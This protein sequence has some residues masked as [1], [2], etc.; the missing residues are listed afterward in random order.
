MVAALGYR[1]GTLGFMGM[2]EL[3]AQ[4]P[5]MASGNYGLL[6]QIHGL[7]W[8]RHHR[9]KFGAAAYAR[10]TIFGQSAGALD[11]SS[12]LASPL[13]KVLFDGVIMESTY[14]TVNFYGLSVSEGWGT[15]CGQ[16]C[17]NDHRQFRDP[18]ACLRNLTSS[19]VMA[20]KF[21]A[22]LV[23]TAPAAPVDGYVLKCPPLKALSSAGECGD[24]PS[25]PVLVGANK[26]EGNQ[27]AMLFGT[28]FFKN[29]DLD[30][31]IWTQYKQLRAMRGVSVSESER[32]A[33][34]AAARK[35]YP[36]DED[37]TRRALELSMAF[38]TSITSDGVRWIDMSQTDVGFVCSAQ[39]TAKALAAQSEP[40]YLYFFTAVPSSPAL[41]LL[42]SAHMCEM[43]YVFGTFNQ[44]A[45]MFAARGW[46]SEWNPTAAEQALSQIV[47]DHWLDF[48]RTGSPGSDWPISRVED[49]KLTGWLNIGLTPSAESERPYPRAKQCEFWMGGAPAV[50]SSED[51]LVL[52]S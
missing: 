4:S 37:V 9:A 48:A 8:L 19:E 3:S 52:F 10:I 13:S 20:C 47:M 28:A 21:P 51:F 2:P 33:S 29:A 36:V 44:F 18:V 34:V 17:L 40:A 1:L 14:P 11:I 46:N 6:D 5:H 12:H 41:K 45:E 23:I 38:N 26:H 43:P 30:D 27:F 7:R 31:L 25:V 32:D 49:D 50:S 35:L 42:G 39:L 24:L 15:Q 22:S 16:K